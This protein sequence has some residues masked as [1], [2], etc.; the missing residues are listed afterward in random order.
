VL[1][2]VLQSLLIPMNRFL[3]FAVILLVLVIA[4]AVR[5]HDLG[6]QSLWNDEGS[7]YV[8]AT[9]SFNEIAVNAAADIH[10]PGYYWTLRI[11]RGFVGETEFA[12]RYLSALVGILTVALTYAIGIRLHP[13]RRGMGVT[14]GLVAAGLTALNTFNIT[15][16][17]ELRM[18]AALALWGAASLWALAGF[19]N[20]PTLSRGL[21]LG[22]I[23]GLGLWTHYAFP[24]VMLAQLA[25]ALAWLS[26]SAA[27]N[28][29]RVL[30]GQLW[31]YVLANAVGIV[32]FAPLLPTALRQVT[33]WPNTG[34]AGVTLM[35]G[36]GALLRTFA[37]GVTALEVDASW[38]AV[39]LI[40][41]LFG[42][43]TGGASHRWRG[44][45]APALL[46]IPTLIFLT[47]GL[48]REGNVKF[49]LP[50]QVGFALAVGQ[51]V[52]VM[53]WFTEMPGRRFRNPRAA[54]L[55]TRLGAGAALMGVGWTLVRA[56]PPLYTDPA[57]ARNDYRAMVA[58]IP[59]DAAVILNAPGQIEVFRY[60]TF[61]T[62]ALPIP[63][64]INSTDAEIRDDILDAIT[65]Y[66]HIY[67]M[68]WGD[69]E[70]DPRR[71]VETTLNTE[72]YIVSSQWY[73]D[74]RLVEY[75][76]PS[77]EFGVSLEP[78]VRFGDQITL[79]E[80]LLPYTE[81]Q[82]DDVIPVQLHWQTDASLDTS[83]RVFLQLIDDEGNLVAARDGEP[84]GWTHPTT[85][86]EPGET[87]VDR[88]GLLLPQ[89]MTASNLTL[90]VGLY[91]P[92]EN[93]ARL[94]IAG[95][96]EDTFELTPITIMEG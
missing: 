1:S 49:L 23:N 11:W 5:F 85:T 93:G 8:Q 72:A 92:A 71:V 25:V 13:S 87:I 86:W 53:A 78:D 38:V 34:D 70:R 9:R 45:L 16:S 24:L 76:A 62:V 28:G 89:N 4:A 21:M 50:S 58:A 52:A 81:W 18:Y 74:V 95:A 30:I 57:Y 41:A 42:L 20:R 36:L 44:L 37:F 55:L 10:P 69:A 79:V 60:Y 14:V 17:Q 82:P 65:R 83:Y 19:F 33:T 90:I 96:T 15:Y 31:R 43:N 46:L 56:L 6:D 27:R 3:Q 51:G 94:P 7:S 67:L 77:D 64:G 84:V 80:A 68:L 26:E 32:F 12:L 2:D 40:L 61:D 39:A 59:A 88:H 29:F 35:T 73:G 63:A 22:G 91:N 47:M 54:R 48:Y 75:V 66:H